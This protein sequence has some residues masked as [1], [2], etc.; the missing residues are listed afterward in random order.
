MDWTIKFYPRNIHDHWSSGANEYI[1]LWGGL[2]LLLTR[3]KA[4]I[5]REMQPRSMETSLPKPEGLDIFLT[6]SL[7]VINLRTPS[8]SL[9]NIIK[10]QSIYKSDALENHAYRNEQIPY[11]Q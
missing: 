4:Q 2:S 9:K 3:I 11:T 7:S 1:K 5:F 8:Q 6:T 10:L